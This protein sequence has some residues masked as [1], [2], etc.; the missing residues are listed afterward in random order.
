[1]IARTKRKE[2]SQARRQLIVETAAACFIEKGFHQTSIRDIARRAGISLGNLYNYFE[3]KTALIAE[4]A[5]LEA[6][7]LDVLKNK[8]SKIT[9]PAKALDRF[10][11]LYTDHCCQQENSVLSAE[12]VSESFR[13]P[14]IGLGFLQNRI[15][16]VTVIADLI[17]KNAEREGVHPEIAPR[18]CAEFILDLIEG[19]AERSAF[20]GI[21]PARKATKALKTA[22]QKLVSV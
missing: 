2:T 10:V 21:G 4:I 12:I 8:L 14:D 5:M 16:L 18:D 3:N 7:E 20:K 9:D 11:S 19:L 15:E 6:S 17:E 1:M 13:S 22:I